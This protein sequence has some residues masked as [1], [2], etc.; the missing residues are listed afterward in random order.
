[1]Q[2]TQQLTIIEPEASDLYIPLTSDLI[3]RPLLSTT[4]LLYP[5]LL[6][7]F[8]LVLSFICIFSM[9]RTFILISFFFYSATPTSLPPIIHSGRTFQ[10]QP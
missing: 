6:H 9:F 7:T 4:I 5:F 2:Y 10:Q 3:N 8:L 1:M